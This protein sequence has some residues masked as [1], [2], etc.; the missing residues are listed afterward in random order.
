MH[1]ARHF[2]GTK[3]CHKQSSLCIALT[4][5]VLKN[6]RCGDIV[7]PVVPKCDLV[8]YKVIN[9]FKTIEFILFLPT[10]HLY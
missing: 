6:F 5:S 8:S 1:S 10:L 9:R 2:A 3:Q 7:I 4:I